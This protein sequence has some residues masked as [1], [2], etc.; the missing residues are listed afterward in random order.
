MPNYHGGCVYAD[1]ILRYLKEHNCTIIYC[2][3]ASW[4]NACRPFFRC[5]WKPVFAEKFLVL[6]SYVRGKYI[7]R[8]NLLSILS[9]PFYL[10]KK[11]FG[12]ESKRVSTTIRSKKTSTSSEIQYVEK[13]V[14]RE[15]PDVVIVDSAQIADVLSLYHDY[16]SRTTLKIILTTDV[17]HKRVEA[18][19]QNNT[20]L[21]FI[22][23]SRDEE[24]RL[25]GLSD[26]VIAIQEN[27]ARE[28]KNMVPKI[29]V[30]VTPMP[31]EIEQSNSNRQVEGRCLFVGGGS[32]HN[33]KG[34]CWFLNSVW[35]R[36]LETLPQASLVVCGSVSEF[37]N[38]NHT[39]LHLLGNVP[40]LHKVY[41]EAMVC[42]V[43]L[44]FGT[45][46]KIKLVEAMA[47]HRA[48]LSTSIG[49]EGFKELENGQ[50]AEVADEPKAFAQALIRLLQDN[51]FRNKC[52]KRQNRWIRESLHPE[53]AFRELLNVINSH[54]IQLDEQ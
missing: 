36:V 53:K 47:E 37:L 15:R 45:G 32:Q 44:Q 24:I 22:P 41:E 46:F 42:I 7:I 39:N 50:V 35:P 3:L 19:G 10:L 28:F 23:L 49:V 14:K 6:D 8:K 26:V 30:I 2:W 18:Y 51:S 1:A 25:L 21:D 48:V 40:D 9:N 43:P 54:N 34:I 11:I 4:E 12:N 52:V 17:V 16:G 13:I 20:T 31:V 29:R 33:V 27:D 38:N 5:P